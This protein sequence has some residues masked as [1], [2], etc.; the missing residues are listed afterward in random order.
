MVIN[1]WDQINDEINEEDYTEYQ[2][3]HF[4]SNFKDHK[5]EYNESKVGLTEEE[6]LRRKIERAQKTL[7]T[8]NK[9][10]YESAC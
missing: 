5:V 7:E 2:W 4:T 6:L 3:L 10:L 1:L 9:K 8:L